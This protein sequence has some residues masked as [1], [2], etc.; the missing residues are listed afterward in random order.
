MLLKQFS[1]QWEINVL[2]KLTVMQIKIN[3]RRKAL[4][5]AVR[6]VSFDFRNVELTAVAGWQVG[7]LYYYTTTS[8]AQQLRRY[9]HVRAAQ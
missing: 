8:I 6:N 3:A 5:T 2:H 7:V 4:Y 9:Y 1:V